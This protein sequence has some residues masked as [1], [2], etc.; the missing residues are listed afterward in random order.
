MVFPLPPGPRCQRL[1]PDQ[2]SLFLTSFIPLSLDYCDR[3]YLMNDVSI[4][5]TDEAQPWSD[6]VLFWMHGHR[7]KVTLTNNMT[8]ILSTLPESCCSK[9]NYY[10]DTFYPINVKIF[11]PCSTYRGICN[12]ANALILTPP[13]IILVWR[14][15][16]PSSKIGKG[17]GEPR[18][19]DLCH[20]QNSGSSNQI[21]ERNSYIILLRHYHLRA[22]CARAGEDGHGGCSGEQSCFGCEGGYIRGT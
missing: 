14:S 12:P 3:W 16:T 4:I 9:K 7:A 21:S 13:E 18:I 1:V 15:L 22:L 8:T 2:S 6:L 17:S 19:I 10:N 5:I 11:T 20:K